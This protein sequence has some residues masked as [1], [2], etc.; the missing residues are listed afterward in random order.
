MSEAKIISSLREN[1]FM[2]NKL[3]TLNFQID[4][5]T[6]SVDIS[7]YAIIQK[8]V[9]EVFSD[10]TCFTIAHR[11]N[12]VMDSDMILVLSEGQIEEFDTPTS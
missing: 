5:A 1:I 6:D 3:S 7:A 10:A 4:E 11:I 12:T 8:I 9:R 2:L